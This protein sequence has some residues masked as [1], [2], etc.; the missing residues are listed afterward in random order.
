MNPD[1]NDLKV[2]LALSRGGS[3]AAA[4]RALKVDQST[5]SRRLAAIEE[6]FDS[7]FLVRGSRE[8]AWTA[9]GKTALA[10]AEAAEAAILAAT[11]RLHSSRL[12]LAGVVRVSV[13]P[14]NAVILLQILPRFQDEYPDLK[15]DLT[16]TVERVDLA[17][18]EADIAFRFGEPTE[19]DLIARHV[20][21][22]G[23]CVFGSESYLR[24]H[25]TPKSSE[26]LPCHHLVLNVPSMHRVGPGLRWLEDFNRQGTATMRVDNLQAAS[27]MIVTGRGLGLL[28]AFFEQTN[29]GLVRALPDPVLFSDGYLVYHASLRDVTRIRVALDV[30]SAAIKAHSHLW[31]GLPPD[32]GQVAAR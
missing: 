3:V 4:A 14:G 11:Q 9:E 5:V 8:F 27:Q 24:Q 21:Q 17:K 25:G 19:P 31:S 6:A 10:A 32:S 7:H 15:L 18:G 22:G 1:W 26:D 13:T 30:M 12:E 16:G 20:T 23:W 2:L 28:P 29:P